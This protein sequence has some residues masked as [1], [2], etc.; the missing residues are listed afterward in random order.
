MLVA[1]TS[2]NTSFFDLHPMSLK[3]LK[4]ILLVK[5]YFEKYFLKIYFEKSFQNIK[6]IS[7]FFLNIFIKAYFRNIE[8]IF[9]KYLFGIYFQKL[10]FKI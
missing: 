10:I 3:N 6:F 5:I 4:N 1:I 2:S 7:Q 8:F 9:L